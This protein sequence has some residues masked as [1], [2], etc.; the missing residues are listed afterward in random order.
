MNDKEIA[1]RLRSYATRYADI[2]R[3][4]AAS[5][6]AL[7]GKDEAERMA[8]EEEQLASYAKRGRPKDGSA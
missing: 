2:A 6:N 8:D 4:F 5:A 1:E 7:D 3:V